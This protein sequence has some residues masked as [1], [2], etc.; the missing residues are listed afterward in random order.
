MVVVGGQWCLI[1]CSW[2][3]CSAKMCTRVTLGR[4]KGRGEEQQ[5]DSVAPAEESLRV[6]VT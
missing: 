4:E 1:C 3:Q 2:H 5:G 6:G